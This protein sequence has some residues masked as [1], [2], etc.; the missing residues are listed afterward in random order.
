[1][2]IFWWAQANFLKVM[3]SG[4]LR[5]GMVVLGYFFST[6][7]KQNFDRSM[8]HPRSRR[9]NIL[10][11]SPSRQLPRGGNL[12]SLAGVH[13]I[14]IWWC[15]LLLYGAVLSVV[16]SRAIPLLFSRASLCR[17]PNAQQAS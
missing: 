12:S 8:E 2:S 5:G 15:L 9:D 11:V 3:R 6:H 16:C 17:P 13:V 10:R 14:N 1:M 4:L 7:A